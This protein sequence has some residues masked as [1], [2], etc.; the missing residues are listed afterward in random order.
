M[1]C[2]L[3]GHAGVELYR[4]WR[5]DDLAQEAGRVASVPSTV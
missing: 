1:S 4:H 3:V 5:S 2:T